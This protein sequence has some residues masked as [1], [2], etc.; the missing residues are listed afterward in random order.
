VTATDYL[1]CDKTKNPPPKGERVLIGD[2]YLFPVYEMIRE[3]ICEIGNCHR[4]FEIESLENKNVSYFDLDCYE[5][6]QDF[7]KIFTDKAKRRGRGQAIAR[8]LELSIEILTIK[9]CS[10]SKAYVRKQE[11]IKD[12][13]KHIGSLEEKRDSLNDDMDSKQTEVDDASGEYEDC[14]ETA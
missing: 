1:E 14:I 5:T 11:L 12:I 2:R 7:K 4:L 6:V 3:E 10:D 13:E 8:L 9:V